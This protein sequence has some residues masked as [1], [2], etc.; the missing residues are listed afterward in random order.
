[1]EMYSG[2]IARFLPTDHEVDVLPVRRHQRNIT[3]RIS[4]TQLTQSINAFRPSQFSNTEP[5]QQLH[6][7]LQCA[8]DGINGII[9]FGEAE[10]STFT[11]ADDQP[12][13]YTITDA[14]EA[15]WITNE[16]YLASF[17]LRRLNSPFLAPTSE[18][19]PFYTILQSNDFVEQHAPCYNSLV[20]VP[21]TQAEIMEMVYCII[22]R[23]QTIELIQP[24][25]VAGCWKYVLRGWVGISYN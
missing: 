19:P 17:L 21:W 8:T 4:F 6:P 23:L 11:V 13:T 12:P 5:A 24:F 22:I 20:T 15:T 1:M 3:E 7:V 25:L 16:P 10:L 18:P 2:S 14:L 9:E